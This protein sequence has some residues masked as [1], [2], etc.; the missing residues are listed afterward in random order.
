[1]WL[2]LENFKSVCM[3]HEPR[4]GNKA[5][6][7]KGEEQTL[8]LFRHPVNNTKYNSAVPLLERNILFKQAVD[9]QLQPQ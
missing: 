3:R 1:M 5:A 4:P 6:H 8:L 7:W 2:E 9:Q